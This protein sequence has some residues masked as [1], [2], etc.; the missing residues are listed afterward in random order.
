MLT[1]ADMAERCMSEMDSIEQNTRTRAISLC[2][3]RMLT[4]ADAC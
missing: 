1:Y 4:Y 3:A 2:V